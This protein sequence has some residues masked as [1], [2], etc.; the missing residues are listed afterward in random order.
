[1]KVFWNLKI[2]GKIYVILKGIFE[3][4]SKFIYKG[5]IEYGKIY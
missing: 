3:K 4:L 1:M 2:K 5:G